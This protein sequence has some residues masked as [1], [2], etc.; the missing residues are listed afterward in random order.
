MEKDRRGQKDKQQRQ[1]GR[2][3]ER[4]MG[5]ERQTD[6]GRGETGD[7]QTDRVG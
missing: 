5:T 7:R 6:R 4:Q 3:K 1:T 2:G